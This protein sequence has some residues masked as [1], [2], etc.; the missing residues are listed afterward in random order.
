[1]LSNENIDKCMK[2]HANFLDKYISKSA[3]VCYTNNRN[4]PIVADLSKRNS[5]DGA[6]VMPNRDLF[7]KSISEH[8]KGKDNLKVLEIGVAN[9][10]NSMRIFDSLKPGIMYL[11]DPW[12]SQNN[13][14]ADRGSNQDQ[15]S[16]ALKEAKERFFIYSNVI[17]MKA[18][19][20]QVVN[21]FPDEYFDFIYVDGDHSYEGCK[22]DLFMWYPKVKFGGFLGGHDFTNNLNSMHNKGYGVQKASC[23]FLSHFNRKIDFLTPC[24]ETRFPDTLLPFDWGFIK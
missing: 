7:F 13:R 6:A 24:V 15:H 4:Q 8:F 2:E 18:Y 10:S 14:A 11:V 21:D 22:K 17:F 16:S 19:A 12:V 9:G 1:M 3:K 20:E 23:E 5:L